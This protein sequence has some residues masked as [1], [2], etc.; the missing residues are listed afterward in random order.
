[1]FPPQFSG[2]GGVAKI[3][4]MNSLEVEVDVSENFIHR[5][6]S[7]Q[8][9]SITL[10]AYPDWNIPAR[11]IA[12]IPTADRTKATVKVRVGFDV[13]DPRIVPEMGAHVWFLEGD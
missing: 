11:V 3:V 13:K 12:L 5:V 2:G 9:A 7:H 6:H 8:P 4:D 10:N 1:M